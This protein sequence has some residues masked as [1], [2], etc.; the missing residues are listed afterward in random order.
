LS[1]VIDTNIPLVVKYP[2]NHPETLVSGCEELLEEILTSETPVATD[3]DG[4]I[5][6]EYFH[7][8]DWS[9]GP[10]LGDAFA[11][12]VH[13]RR[14]TW[15][16]RYRPDIGPLGLNSY[17]ALQNDDEDFDPSDRKFIAV[18]KLADVAVHQATDTKWLNW[19]PALQRH[20]VEVIYVDEQAIRDAYRAKFGHD[21]P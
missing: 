21:A 14:F 9:G 17:T 15:D 13:D 12:W 4:E 20:G 16:E 5:V 19:G 11:K 10:T 18:A 3:L 1:G 8:L 7:Q 2:D 6:E